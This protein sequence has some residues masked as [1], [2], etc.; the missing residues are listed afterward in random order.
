MTG[1]NPTR[2]LLIV[3]VIFLDI[4]NAGVEFSSEFQNKFIVWRQLATI[5][6]HNAPEY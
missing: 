2:I 5:K 6:D 3:A 1:R 4:A